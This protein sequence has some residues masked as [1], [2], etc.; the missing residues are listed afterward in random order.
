MQYQSTSYFVNTTI[1][2]LLRARPPSK[3]SHEQLVFIDDTM[4]ANDELTARQLCQLLDYH[5]PGMT[6]SLSTVKRARRCLGWIATRPK[7]CQLIREANKAKR[8][9]RCEERLSD[10]DKFEYVIFTNECSV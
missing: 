8:K 3:L 10:R 2:D 7:Y 4:A 1:M 6:L 5:W 9:L